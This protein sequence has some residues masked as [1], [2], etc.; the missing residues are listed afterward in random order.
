MLIEA[1]KKSL[2]K[3][4]SYKELSGVMDYAVLPAGKLF[5]PKLVQAMALDL[6]GEVTSDHLH[7]AS[8]IE[9]HHAYTL[10]HD[11]LPAMDN[12]LIRRGK[13][14][15][16]AQFGEWKAI[17]AGDALLIASFDELNKIEH[18]NYRRL[19]K[20]FAWA[21]GARG[22][23][24]GQF[25]DLKANGKQTIAD[26]IRIHEL[27]TA[28]LIQTATLG[29]HLLSGTGSAKS[30]RDFL[31]LG[32]EIGVSFQLLDDLNELKDPRVSP[33]EE[34]INP[35]LVSPTEALQ[36]LKKSHQRLRQI[37]TQ[38]KLKNLEVMLGEYF[39]NNQREITADW[40]TVEVN[41]T[42]TEAKIEIY[43]WITS[44]V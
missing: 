44:F 37:L 33:H 41:L 11:D 6:V 32:R 34:L 9:L 21:T 28:R 12:D 27:K 23:I 10:V 17:L 26:T 8:A 22:L 7:L 24:L 16:H 25:L 13:A 43:G 15:T 18:K 14:S 39:K 2:E 36:E 3:N 40:K 19:M 31:R 20:I 30:F 4:S 38:Y 29:T 1:L 42:K 5:R 35:F